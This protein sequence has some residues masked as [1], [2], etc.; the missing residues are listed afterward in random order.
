MFDKYKY[1]LLFTSTLKLR[2]SKQN[3]DNHLAL[4][5][6]SIGETLE[7]R[8]NLLLLSDAIRAMA[9]F[10]ETSHFTSRIP[11]ELLKLHMDDENHSHHR[12]SNVQ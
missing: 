4:G 3:R 12:D 9:S 7:S 10:H 6:A 5:R 11:R 2:K 1:I 8:W